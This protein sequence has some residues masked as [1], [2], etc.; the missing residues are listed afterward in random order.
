M[1]QENEDGTEKTEEPTAKKLEKARE[2]GQIMRSSEL[3]VAAGTIV[4]LLILTLAGQY[5]V[6]ELAEIFKGAFVFDRK[7]IYSPNLLPARFIST[8]GIALLTFAPLFFLLV[9]VA[10]LA[11]SALGGL[12]F[13]LKA[14]M[15]KLSKMN[16]L[17][18]LKR[19]FGTQA[20]IN[21]VKA[22]LKFGLVAG[23]MYLVIR[24]QISDLLTLSQLSLEPAL[25]KAATIIIK[26]GLLVALTLLIIAAIDI[27]IQVYQFTEN[28]KMT[29]QEVKDEM[30]DVEGR[31]EVKQKIKQRQREIAASQMMDK[32]KDADVVITN[33]EH[34]SVALSY[35][36]TSDGAPIILAKGADYLAFRIREEAQKHG[37]QMFAA[38]PLARALYFTTEIDQPVHPDL[39]YAVAQVIA[40]IFNLNSIS[41][42]GLPPQKP[43]PEIPSSMIFDENGKTV[44]N[45]V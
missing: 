10:I 42:E 30:K 8:L 13:S 40:Y 3:G 29:L 26:S 15:P 33:P 24:F 27:P 12:N 38:P 31:P 43:K 23:V 44:E 37:I 16:P 6:T 34:F 11:G 14:M 22:L 5:F 25:A 36:P 41:S 32:V 39:Y 35:D 28:M 18:G 9:I 45:V 19:M 4:G 21:L 20:I 1:A 7:I 17:S 2:E